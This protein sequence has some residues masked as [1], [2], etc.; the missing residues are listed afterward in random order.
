[1]R[2]RKESVGILRV[3]DGHGRTRAVDG[4]WMR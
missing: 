3:K 4:E 2:V 1:M